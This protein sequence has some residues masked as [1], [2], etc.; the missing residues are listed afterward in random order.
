MKRRRIIVLD[1]L[2]CVLLSVAVWM[3]S[4]ST[5][6]FNVEKEEVTVEKE[7]EF[8][9]VIEV[10]K[11]FVPLEVN[12]DEEVQ[13]YIWNECTKND[14]DFH[15]M[16]ALAF[17]ES[18]YKEDAF[19]G[20]DYGLFQIRDVN[21]DWVNKELGRKLDYMSPYDNTDAAVLMVSKLNNK[22]GD[23]GIER[24][25]MAY[26][27]GETGAKRLWDKGIYSSDYSRSVL[28]YRGRLVNP[29]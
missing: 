7:E 5:S 6:L 3:A 9:E 19:N 27:C 4:L 20:R 13:E 15:V 1:A 29:E 17:K 12:L 26:N 18:S 10:S 11:V 2:I 25:L 22:Y 21:H 24:V 28:E 23:K 16:M 8:I 14:L